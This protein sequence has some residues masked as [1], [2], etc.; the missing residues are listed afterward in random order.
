VRPSWIK[1]AGYFLPP[2]AQVPTKFSYGRDPIADYRTLFGSRVEPDHVKVEATPGYLYYPESAEWINTALPNSLI[3]IS[4]REQVEWLISWFKMLKAL[5]HLEDAI[6]FD[7]WIEMMATDPRPWRE[8]PHHLSALDQGHHARVVG[9]YLD[10][11]GAERVCITWL[12]ELDHHP[13]EEMRRISSFAGIDESFFD[14]YDFRVVNAAVRLRDPRYH[15]IY[16]RVRRKVV[17][18]SSGHA[19]VRERVDRSLIK[20]DHWFYGLVTRPAEDVRPSPATV[21]MLRELYADDNARLA[22]LVAR[23]VPWA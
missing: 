11:F 6:T 7:T 5:G 23:P 20:L 19:A 4:L 17:H 12:A 8:R 13:R 2:D 3:V 16:T 9:H 18:L 22:R 21:T 14:S 1:E 10:V 15:E